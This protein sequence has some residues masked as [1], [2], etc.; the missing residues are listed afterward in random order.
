MGS[1]GGGDPL[2]PSFAPPPR[3]GVQLDSSC[4][5]SKAEARTSSG[6][7]IS[8][9]GHESSLGAVIKR[10]GAHALHADAPWI[11]RSIDRS[12]GFGSVEFSRHIDRRWAPP[13]TFRVSAEIRYRKVRWRFRMKK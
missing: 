11:D 6:Q 10:N 13:A 5:L 12:I 8:F 4:S 1:M 3:S 2:F 7:L 9:N